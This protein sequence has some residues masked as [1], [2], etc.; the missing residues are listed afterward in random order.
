M[1]THLSATGYLLV[2]KLLSCDKLDRDDIWF[3]VWSYIMLTINVRD[4]TSA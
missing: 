4:T 1:G 2:D 3:P